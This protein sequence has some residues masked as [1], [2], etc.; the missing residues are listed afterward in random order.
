MAKSKKEHQAEQ[1]KAIK[2][3]SKAIALAMELNDMEGAYA[4]GRQDEPF[5]GAATCAKATLGVAFGKDTAEAMMR[6]VWDSGQYSVGDLTRY[7]RDVRRETQEADWL[8]PINP[9]KKTAK[10]KKNP[11]SVSSLLSRALK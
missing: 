6:M 7:A 11:R 2:I 4:N 8:R 9:R 5:G 3:A 10:R 1:R